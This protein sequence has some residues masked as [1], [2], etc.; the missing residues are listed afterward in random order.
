MNLRKK[1]IF[2]AKQI[3]SQE[4]A[5]AND[6]AGNQTKNKDNQR[7]SHDDNEF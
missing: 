7:Y 4:W 6:V 3:M 5:E 2:H 1:L